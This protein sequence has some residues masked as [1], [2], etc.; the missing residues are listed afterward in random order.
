MTDNPTPTRHLIC[1]I[2]RSSR[3][4]GMY[5][6]ID[7]P[8]GLGCVPEALMQQ[9]GTPRHVSDML[10][11][12]KRALAR[13]DTAK[14]REALLAQGWYLQM[15]PPPDTDLYLAQGHPGRDA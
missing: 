10:L 11:R 7:K 2:Y 15:P 5:L 13:V 4:E 3:R 12:P 1:S 9:F 8:R 6:Y 14:V